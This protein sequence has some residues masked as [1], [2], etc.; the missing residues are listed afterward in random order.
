MDRMEKMRRD[1]EE[2]LNTS[3][4]AAKNELNK[5]IKDLEQQV[6]IAAEREA[7]L[8]TKTA[9]VQAELAAMTRMYHLEK[10]F[11]ID[12]LKNCVTSACG[13]RVAGQSQSGANQPTLYH[14]FRAV[15]GSQC[16]ALR[17][18]A[19]RCRSETERESGEV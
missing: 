11:F 1:L 3:V 18:R 6:Q 7:G 15:L 9:Q 12:F 10:V 13:E 14:V 5:R 2:K 4:T 17:R 19:A 16:W 8:G